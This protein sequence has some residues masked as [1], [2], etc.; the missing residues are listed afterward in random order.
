MMTA[1]KKRFADPNTDRGHASVP[2]RL[3]ASSPLSMVAGSVVSALG[4]ITTATPSDESSCPNHRQLT[5]QRGSDIQEI[6][7]A[8]TRNGRALAFQHQQ[9]SG[10]LPKRRASNCWETSNQHITASEHRQNNELQQRR[11]LVRW[12][13]P[14]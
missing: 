1:L 12:N 4:E 2:L 14:I 11:V 5:R 8:A 10:R 13:E 3:Q 6:S 9:Q 7:L